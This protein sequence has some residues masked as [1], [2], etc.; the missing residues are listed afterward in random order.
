MK[1]V[2]PSVLFT[3]ILCVLIGYFEPANAAKAFVAAEPTTGYV[4]MNSTTS[5]CPFWPNPVAPGA[6]ITTIGIDVPTSGYMVNTSTGTKYGISITAYNQPFPLGV[7]E[8][9]NYFPV[10]EYSSL[11]GTT[12]NIPSVPD[13]NYILTINC[14]DGNVF[15]TKVSFSSK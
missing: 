3:L 12:L 14:A 13:G 1:Q 15:N 5:Y 4:A 7:V 10:D 2:K 9:N 11:T 8:T 6:V